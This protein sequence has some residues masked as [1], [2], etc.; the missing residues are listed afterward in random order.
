MMKKLVLTAVPLLAAANQSIEIAPFD[1]SNV[2]QSGEPISLIKNYVQYLLGDEHIVGDGHIK[3]GSCDAQQPKVFIQDSSQI[4]AKPDP[5][6]KGIQVTFHLGGYLSTDVKI[7]KTEVSVQW[8]GTPLYKQDFPVN[9]IK[10]E[11]DDFSTEL[12]WL[13]PSFA[14]SGHYATQILLWGKPE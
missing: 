13:I 9:E 14:P 12:T 5:V 10:H 7:T 1:P 4:Y 2:L 3:F 11:Q 6:K 8:G